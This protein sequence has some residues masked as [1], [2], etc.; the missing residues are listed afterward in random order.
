[1]SVPVDDITIYQGADLSYRMREEDDSS[2][3]V[4]YNG[5]VAAMQFKR[6]YDGQP[7]LSLSSTGQ[8]P[9]LALDVT[10]GWLSIHI[11][12]AQTRVLEGGT[13]GLYDIELTRTNDG[14]VKRFVQGV[15]NV[16]PE[17]TT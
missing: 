7:I 8:S 17:V 14:F 2:N 5:W 6:N 9:G 10:D 11:T 1:M 4:T 12:A 3:P 13:S 16:D 15:Y